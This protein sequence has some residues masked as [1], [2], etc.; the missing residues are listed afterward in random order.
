M[1]AIYAWSM[2]AMALPLLAIVLILVHYILRRAVWRHGRRRRW[3]R[4]GYYPSS[5][6]LGLALQF[7]QMY[8]RPSV[9][10]VLDAKQDE[11]AKE[12]DNGD[13]ESLNRQLHRQLRRIRRGEPVDRLVLRI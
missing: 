13:P 4:L 2:I 5:L 11:D 3:K 9:E 1:D 7:V 12:D 10:Y 6:A 8:Y